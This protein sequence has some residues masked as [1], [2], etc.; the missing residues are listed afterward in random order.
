[1]T[2][3]FSKSS[4]IKHEW[5]RDIKSEDHKKEKEQQ[6]RQDDV[7]DPSNDHDN[8]DDKNDNISPDET[9]ATQGTEGILKKVG[10]T[11]SHNPSIHEMIGET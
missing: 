5:A 7:K 9:W 11:I 4:K 2:S 1:M 3:L 6:P 8:D 10:N